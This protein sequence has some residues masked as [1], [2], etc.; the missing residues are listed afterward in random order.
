MFRL[1]LYIYCQYLKII[2]KIIISKNN[3]YNIVSI[4]LDIYKNVK[5]FEILIYIYIIHLII[6]L[7]HCFPIEKNKIILKNKYIF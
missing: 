2:F 5:K 1:L 7:Y 6:S 4:L 3:Q